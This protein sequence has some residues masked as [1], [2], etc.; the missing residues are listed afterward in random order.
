MQE[1]HWSNM[2][3]NMVLNAKT[4]K[5]KL[6]VKGKDEFL[7]IHPLAVYFKTYFQLVRLII[8]RQLVANLRSLVNEA[9]TLITK[10]GWSSS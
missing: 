1:L 5:D 7:H 10:D 6:R 9:K 8:E 4:F 2:F 3:L